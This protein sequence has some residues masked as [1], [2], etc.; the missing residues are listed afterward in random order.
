MKNSTPRPEPSTVIV[1][2]SGVAANAGRDRLPGKHFDAAPWDF[3]RPKGIGQERLTEAN[4][5]LLA[6]LKFNFS[7]NIEH[8][9]EEA[10]SDVRDENP[11][12]LFG[13]DLGTLE[14]ITAKVKE[15]VIFVQN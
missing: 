12:K 14:K 1:P 8:N 4:K 2:G 5:A 9:V 13:N 11:V 10:A 3:T 15:I 7:Q 6:Q